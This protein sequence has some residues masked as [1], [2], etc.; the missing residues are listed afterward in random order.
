L[1]RTTVIGVCV[2]TSFLTAQPSCPGT[3]SR[4]PAHD[5]CLDIVVADAI[6]IGCGHVGG[7]G[8]LGERR[9]WLGLGRMGPSS[10]CS[11]MTT[12]TF[13]SWRHCREE[14]RPRACRAVRCRKRSARRCAIGSTC[15][16]RLT[17]RR[18]AC[19]RVRSPLA[20]A[21]LEPNQPA[22]V[23]LSFTIG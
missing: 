16:R 11:W 6:P 7:L 22:S 4:R 20:R 19:V 13:S 10:F 23:P 2:P 15:G 14:T 3:S 9:L 12:A 1:P 8:L 17:P 18:S 21:S 5:T